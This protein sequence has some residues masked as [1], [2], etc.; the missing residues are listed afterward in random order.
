MKFKFNA[1][2]NVRIEVERWK[3]NKGLDVYVSSLG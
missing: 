1:M 3:Y 2:P